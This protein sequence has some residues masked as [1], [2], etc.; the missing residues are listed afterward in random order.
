MGDG[1]V[2]WDPAKADANLAKHGISFE[3]AAEA[4]GDPFAIVREDGVHS[5]GE[6]RFIL[7]G[8]SSE[9]LTLTV[10]FTVRQE[11]ARIISA[12]RATSAERRRYME[13]GETIHDGTP[14]DEMLED[15]GHF[16][17]WTR[18]PFRFRVAGRVTLDPDV[19][20]FYRTSDEVNSALRDLIR[21]G[22]AP[23]SK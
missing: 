23:K 3:E 15:Y 18:N 10:V 17:D 19:R 20:R 6:E 2:E 14:E 7:V 16:D 5:S 8:E 9:Q 1:D 21:E 12:R 4:L 22:R 11:V 13:K